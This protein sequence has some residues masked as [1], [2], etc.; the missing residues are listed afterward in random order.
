[1]PAHHAVEMATLN[2][3]KALGLDHLI[4]S[5]ETGK[6][7]DLVAI[8]VDDI[9]QLPM[10]HPESNIVYST[11]ANQVSHA[12]CRGVPLLRQGKL[13]TINTTLLKERVLKWQKNAT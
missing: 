8:S 10:Y 1:M 4:G 7:A 9:N 2:G 5:I 12:W 6:H 3:A 13:T 11:Q